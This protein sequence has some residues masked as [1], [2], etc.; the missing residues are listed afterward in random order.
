MIIKVVIICIYFKF[1]VNIYIYM[2]VCVCVCVCVCIIFYKIYIVFVYLIIHDTVRYMI[3]K[4]EKT[5]HDTNHNLTTMSTW[6]PTAWDGP[7]LRTCQQIPYP[8]VGLVHSSK[9]TDELASHRHP[10]ATAMQ[11]DQ[12]MLLFESFDHLAQ[13]YFHLEIEFQ[14]F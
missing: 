6:T 7:Y 11:F 12:R 9:H 1:I 2:C 8:L 3:H 10:E 5:I 14:A 13:F 4:N